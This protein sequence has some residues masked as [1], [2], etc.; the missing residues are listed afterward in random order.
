MPASSVLTY[1]ET[2]YPAHQGPHHPAHQIKVPS[3]EPSS[4]STPHLP[5]AFSVHRQKVS[6][7]HTGGIL[8]SVANSARWVPHGVSFSPRPES[9][10]NEPILSPTEA[11][12][13]FTKDDQQIG[14][15][16]SPCSSLS[17]MLPFIASKPSLHKKLDVPP[18]RDSLQKISEPPIRSNIKPTVPT[19]LP[20]KTFTSQSRRQSIRTA[21]DAT[22]SI[23][24]TNLDGLRSLWS[25]TAEIQV[26]FTTELGE[27]MGQL[28]TRYRGT[29]FMLYASAADVFLHCVPTHWLNPAMPVAGDIYVYH[30]LTPDL[31]QVFFFDEKT[32]A[33]AK[34]LRLKTEGRQP[35]LDNHATTQHPTQHQWFLVLQGGTIGVHWYTHQTKERCSSAGTSSR[36]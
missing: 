9:D 26:T 15:P 7:V 8:K 16:L 18:S 22:T 27:V 2:V 20:K 35:S 10:S 1:D 23:M 36:Y 12:G 5:G 28:H 6:T 24:A 11:G 25:P 21:L 32:W 14:P 4:A 34:Q 30:I 17:D 13:I 31:Y 33:K 29:P 19:S 3:L